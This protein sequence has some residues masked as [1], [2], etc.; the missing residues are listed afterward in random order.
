[1]LYVA[2]LFGAKL[3]R[4]QVLPVENARK[5]VARTDAYS[6]FELEIAYKLLS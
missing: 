4:I 6:T 1:M 3:D 2:Y 5:N